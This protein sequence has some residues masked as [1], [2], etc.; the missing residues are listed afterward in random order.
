MCVRE[1]ESV[2]RERKCVDISRLPAVILVTACL[3]ILTVFRLCSGEE[4]GLRQL[5]R[6]KRKGKEKKK[7]RRMKVLSEVSNALIDREIGVKR[8]KTKA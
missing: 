1:R 4:W 2:K 5:G 3:Y 6:E 7:R 8:R